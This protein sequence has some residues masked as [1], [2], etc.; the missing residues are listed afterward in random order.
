MRT[1]NLNQ[2]TMGVAV[3][4]ACV[5][6]PDAIAQRG[7]GPQG[8]QV[9]SPEVSADRRVTFRILAAKAETVRLSG[10]DIPEM[11]RARK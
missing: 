7:R 10:G 4:A 8:P 2:F 9:V 3:W 1:R 5:L 6:V 11:A